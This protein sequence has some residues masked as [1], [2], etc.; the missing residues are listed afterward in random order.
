MNMEPEHRPHSLPFYL[1]WSVAISVG[2]TAISL[3]VCGLTGLCKTEYKAT[4]IEQAILLALGGSCYAVL[5]GLFFGIIL[6]LRAR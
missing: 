4:P 2:L 1:L 5:P 6:W 3:A